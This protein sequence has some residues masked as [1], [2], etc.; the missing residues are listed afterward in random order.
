MPVLFLSNARV[1]VISFRRNNK[2]YLIS[3]ACFSADSR[4][5]VER[6][7][8]AEYYWNKSVPCVFF[9]F[10]VYWLIDVLCTPFTT[11]YIVANLTKYSLYKMKCVSIREMLLLDIY[12]SMKIGETNSYF[13]VNRYQTAGLRNNK[14]WKYQM[15]RFL[16]ES[17]GLETAGRKRKIAIRG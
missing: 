5:Q 10:D 13:M 16:I 3:K 4:S 6:L 2:A 11:V 15:T 1:E 9:V 17:L 7:Q 8:T 14:C 12:F